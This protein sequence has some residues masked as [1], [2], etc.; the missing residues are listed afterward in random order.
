MSYIILHT[1]EHIEIISFTNTLQAHYI[2][3]STHG[4]IFELIDVCDLHVIV[5]AAKRIYMQRSII[6]HACNNT[7]LIDPVNG[8]Q[9]LLVQSRE[10]EAER[11]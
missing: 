3:N 4:Y 9:N 5:I 7:D 2:L 6:I 8:H 1:F 10:T 11:R